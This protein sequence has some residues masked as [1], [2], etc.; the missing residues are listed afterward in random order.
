MIRNQRP[1]LYAAQEKVPRTLGPRALA[2][3]TQR[4]SWEVD[5]FITDPS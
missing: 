3:K 1:R 5:A 2:P 4:L